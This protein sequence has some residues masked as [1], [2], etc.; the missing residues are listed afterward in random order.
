MHTL[1]EAVSCLRARAPV[2]PRVILVLGSGLG[3]LAD[4][5]GEP[6]V[7]PYAGIPGFPHSTVEG[8]RGRLL[9]G[10]LEGTP[11]AAMQGRFH[12]YEGFTPE[13]VVFPVRAL[14]ELGATT[15]VVTNSAGAVSPRL[16]PGELM[17]IADHINLLG[18]NPLT[19]PVLAGEERF[20]DMSSPY[21]PGLRAAAR[22]VALEG[23]VWLSEG[24]YAA[25]P[26]PSYETPAEVRALAWLGAD[27]VGMSTVP[28]VLAARARGL[29][30]L[31]ISCLTNLAAGLGGGPLS[32]D[33]V[34]EVGLR[35]RGRLA[36]LLRGTLARIG[37][38]E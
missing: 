16:R 8:H 2:T 28:E 1:P 22:K 12:L 36:A 37:T 7:I 4:E 31:G 20:P 17:L 38:G 23:G 19:G 11:V 32:H 34:I 35:A 25:V 14:A 18:A 21:H 6:V 10:E 9:F 3:G 5:L 33:E 30:V 29:R 24:V 15:L 27:A 26:G 13:Q